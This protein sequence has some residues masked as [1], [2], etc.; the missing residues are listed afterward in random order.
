MPK[1]FLD[2]LGI[3]QTFLQMTVARF[4]K[5]IPVENILIVTSEKYQNLI[6]EQVPEILEENILLEPYK[7]N[8][9]PCIAYATYKLFAKNPEATVVI[10]PSDHLIVNESAFESTISDVLKYASEHNELFTVGIRPSNPNTNYGYIQIDKNLVYNLNGT[11]MNKIKTFTEK[12]DIDLAKVFLE[13]GE[14][15]W[16]SGMFIWNLKTIKKELEHYLP[17]VATLFMSG[18]EKYNTPEESAFIQNVYENSPSISIDYGVMEK[19]KLAWVYPASFGWSDVG[20]W[21]SLYEVSDHKKDS[22][23]NVIS[24][25]N[26][27]VADTEGCLLFEK[28]KDKLLVAKNLK[29]FMIVDTDDVLMVCPRNDAAIKEILASLVVEDKA[30][31]L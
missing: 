13:T 8:T 19:T 18:K 5:I 15:Y 12:P 11:S 2:I 1:Q 25:Q 14:F 31:Y 23:A 4:S 29:N 6:R 30:K 10:S 3:G 22:N 7:R 26:A 27:L 9:A 21:E 28:N 17:E 16:N 24:A 20:T